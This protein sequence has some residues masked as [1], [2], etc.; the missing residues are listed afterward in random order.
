MKQ[1]TLKLNP[2]IK[3]I[4]GFSYEDFNLENYDYHPPLK[5]PIVNVGGF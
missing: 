5:A 2:D 3:D 4:D 1:M